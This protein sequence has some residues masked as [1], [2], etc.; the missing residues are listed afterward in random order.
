ME[1]KGLKT[2]EQLVDICSPKFTIEQR[3]D[4]VGK[5]TLTY[6]LERER[7][8]N[9]DQTNLAFSQDGW[10]GGRVPERVDIFVQLGDE[11]IEEADKVVDN[12]SFVEFGRSLALLNGLSKLHGVEL[13]L[14]LL[15]AS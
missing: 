12:Q 4:L 8:E 3:F 1:H 11:R 7:D 13:K 6:P 9:T 2:N 5:V 14:G 15:H 10:L